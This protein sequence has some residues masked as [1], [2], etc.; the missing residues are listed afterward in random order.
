MLHICIDSDDIDFGTTKEA[1]KSGQNYV[2]GKCQIALGGKNGLS[3][4]NCSLSPF[5]N[6]IP[7]VRI[8]ALSH[9]AP[10]SQ[11]A[12]VQQLTNTLATPRPCW[13]TQIAREE[14]KFSTEA[15]SG[16]SQAFLLSLK[17][18][19]SRRACSLK[20]SPNLPQR[21]GQPRI[22]AP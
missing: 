1:V 19:M 2:Q 21:G 13:T 20:S 6:S 18:T 5:D 16:H 14:E 7:F 3:K 4:H 15:L 22:G 10:A 17:I 12:A 11:F 9:D 8:E